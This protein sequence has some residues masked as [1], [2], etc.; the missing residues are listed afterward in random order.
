MGSGRF[1]LDTRTRTLSSASALT[2]SLNRGFPPNSLPTLILMCVVGCTCVYIFSCTRGASG[3]WGAGLSV[4]REHPPLNPFGCLW[5]E[6]ASVVLFVL[7]SMDVLCAFLHLQYQPA[8]PVRNQSTSNQLYRLGIGGNC[9]NFVPPAGVMICMLLTR[10]FVY[11][12]CLSL[13]IQAFGVMV[14]AIVPPL[15]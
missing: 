8:F 4:R 11:L 6:S 10:V 14:E 1:G 5:R 9:E 7:R 2:F 15:A 3:A 13:N 12:C